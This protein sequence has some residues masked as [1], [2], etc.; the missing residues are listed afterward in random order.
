MHVA[1]RPETSLP[2]LEGLLLVG[3][4]MKLG[5]YAA[6]ASVLVL[7]YM[8]RGVVGFPIRTGPTECPDGRLFELALPAD[9][10]LR[11]SGDGINVLL[12]HRVGRMSGIRHGSKPAVADAFQRSATAPS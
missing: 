4:S 5:V 9:A 10:R 12:R 6:A 7:V 8:I 2:K 11:R 1:P 3:I